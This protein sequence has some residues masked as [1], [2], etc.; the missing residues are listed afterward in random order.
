MAN[1]INF[2]AF[3]IPYVGGSL[4][5][6]SPDPNDQ[7]LCAR[8]FQLAMISPLNIMEN[9]VQMFEPLYFGPLI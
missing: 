5:G 1:L 9:E 8:Y 4:C 2:G 3:G 7:E 6:Y